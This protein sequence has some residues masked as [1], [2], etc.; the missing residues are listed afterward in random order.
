MLKT[1][2]HAQVR[3]FERQWRY[4]AAYLHEMIDT[5]PWA[6]LRFGLVASLGHLGGA[7]AAARAAAGIVGTLAGDCGPCTQISVD[8]AAMAGVKPEV[9]RA[10]LAGDRAG[11]GEVAVLGYDFARAVL[12]RNLADAD[13]IRDEIERRWGR[14]GVLSLSLALTTGGMYPTLKYGLGHGKT[15]SRV[16]V[17]GEPAPRRG[18]ISPSPPP[19]RH[20]HRIRPRRVHAPD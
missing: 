13:E 5:D 3:G 16:V 14:K 1:I 18:H 8:I 6:Y 19:G 9:L 11:M 17:A 4:D 12:D 2:L 10:V 20:G 7:P 15:C